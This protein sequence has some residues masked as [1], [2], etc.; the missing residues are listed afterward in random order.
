MAYPKHPDATDAP[1][2]AV[3]HLWDLPSS[4]VPDDARTQQPDIG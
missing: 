4:G 3:L 2:L 1:E